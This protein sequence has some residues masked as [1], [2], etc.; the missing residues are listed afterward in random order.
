MCF[1][2]LFLMFG[3]GHIHVRTFISF[4]TL[5]PPSSLL[6]Y[7]LLALRIP[8]MILSH[9][10]AYKRTLPI[11]YCSFTP[12]STAHKQYYLLTIRAHL[13]TYISISTSTL[14]QRLSLSLLVLCLPYSPV[15]VTHLPFPRLGSSIPTVYSC[16]STSRTLHLYDTALLSFILYLLLFSYF[17]LV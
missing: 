11:V 13:H 2:F 12:T 3:D 14:P 4:L 9:P 17:R 16:N 15:A 5:I 10:I 7:L 1:A 6:S 8:F